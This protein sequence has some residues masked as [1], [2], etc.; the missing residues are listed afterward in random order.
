MKKKK[1]LI[2]FGT[3]KIAELANYYFTN[4][5]EYE[6][7]CFTADKGYISEKTF[8]ELPIV[9]FEMLEN[10]YDV[11]TNFIFIALSYSELNEIRKKKYLEAKNK[12]F[13]IASYI[14]SHA[15][16]LNENNIGENAFILENNTVQPYSVIGDNV[17]LWSGNHIGH[18]SVI[19]DHSF[20]SSHVV[21]SGGVK[22]GDQCFL[23]VNSTIR[24]HISI[25]SK[26]IIGAGALVLENLASNT[27]LKG[28]DQ[29][30]SKVVNSSIKKL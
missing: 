10:E 14:S 25:G 3:G 19:G 30:I 20:I 26:S 12:G 16:I 2:I 24:D 29:K 27:L 8:C 28:I 21:I 6:V 5:S 1:N 18:H 22:I 15:T 13:K 23:G 9:P 4:D 11:K 17:T 7:I